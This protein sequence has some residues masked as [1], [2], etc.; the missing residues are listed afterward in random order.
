MMQ[1]AVGGF[2][3]HTPAAPLELGI[4]SQHSEAEHQSSDQ[5]KGAQGDL[6]TVLYTAAV[7]HMQRHGQEVQRVQNALRGSAQRRIMSSE[8]D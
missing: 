2:C 4:F 8:S 3:Y 1:S 7:L 6:L 5:N